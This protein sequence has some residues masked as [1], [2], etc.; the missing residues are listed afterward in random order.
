MLLPEKKE[1]ENQGF[2]WETEDEKGHKQGEGSYGR[3]IIHGMKPEHVEYMD[4]QLFTGSPEEREKEE[5]K[6]KESEKKEDKK[7]EREKEKEKTD[8]EMREMEETGIT[9]EK[10]DKA[11]QKSEELAKNIEEVNRELR[12]LK[13][14]L[15]AMKGARGEAYDQMHK[16]WAGYH[17]EAAIKTFKRP[18]GEQ[19]METAK[20]E[21][22][23]FWYVVNNPLNASYLASIFA[24]ESGFFA[25][26]GVTL[27]EINDWREKLNKFDPANIKKLQTAIEKLS[28]E[29]RRELTQALKTDPN[30]IGELIKLDASGITEKIT[31]GWEEGAGK[32]AGKEVGKEAEKEVGKGQ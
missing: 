32:E 4:A 10:W 19:Y 14:E 3:Y 7:R 22:G 18:F 29:M 28:I 12:D 25:P 20:N 6:R 1:L 16:S 9:G 24:P 27:A 23:I 2:I 11:K 5:K 26:E 30:R 17:D 15:K 21:K 13:E 31:K 8:E